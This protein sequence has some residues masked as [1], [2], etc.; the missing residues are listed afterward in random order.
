MYSCSVHKSYGSFKYIFNS[1]V[2]YMIRTYYLFDICIVCI[3]LKG[4]SSLLCVFSEV[5][6]KDIDNYTTNDKLKKT[7]LRFIKVTYP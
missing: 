7:K 2:K 3:Y 4:V 5:L 6:T 1:E